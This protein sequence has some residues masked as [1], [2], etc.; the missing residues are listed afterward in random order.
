MAQRTFR[1][2][3]LAG[4]L[5]L[6][7]VA[8]ACGD[9]SE[10]SDGTKTTQKST[11][12]A[13]LDTTS[14][15]KL[16]Y[17]K[18]APKG[19]TFTDY[20][21]M[22]DSGTNTSFD[23][24]VVQTLN[25]SQITTSLFDGL[26]DFDFSDKCNPELKGAVAEDWEGNE[27]ATEF[28]FNIK[29]DQVFS[30]GT[31]V[32]PSSFKAGWERAGSAELASP[33]GYL[34]SYIKGGDVLQAGCADD[35]APEEGADCKEPAPDTLDAIVADDDAMT[36]TVT[37]AS[38]NA[39]FPSIVSHPFFSPVNKK[40][41]AKIGKTTGWGTKGL[42]I[43]NGPFMLDSS[44]TADADTTLVPNPKWT[45]NVY[46][47]TEV[48]LD[49]LVFKASLDVETAYQTFEAGEGDDA[50]VPSG[51]YQ[52]ALAAYKKNTVEDPNVGSY[53][54]DFGED[55]PQVGGPENVKLRQAI[56]LA[57]DRE[58]INT[59]VY[60]G[61]RQISTGIVPPG[62]PGY[63]ADLSKFTKLD[64]T[65]AKKLYK[66]WQDDGGKL[67]KPIRIDFNE[68][69]SHGDVAQIVQA[70]IKDNLGI[71][72][73]LGGVAEDYFKVVAEPGGCQLCRAG[74]YAD[75]PTYGNFMVDL[76]SKASIGANNFGRFEN[77]D[78][79]KAIK[80]AQ[81]E[82]DDTKRGELYNEAEDIL[83]NKQTATVP[84]VYYTGGQVFN[85]RVSN[86]DQP[87]LGIMLWERVAV[88]G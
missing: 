14:C 80:E 72:T 81:A 50:P 11:D 21:F 79:E 39:D 66:E 76:F 68:G 86:Y 16:E 75:Y 42:T 43:G 87:P 45:G 40:D 18:D 85:D 31:P 73:E 58:E 33:Y 5:A 67:T 37:L 51:K 48:H 62:I 17:D 15:G 64:V 27:D 29:D 4:A 54:F 74:W 7:L 53:Y 3:L 28:K 10:S 88:D 60:E 30:D 36:L 49:K 6:A 55:D 23:P 46:G 41:L 9:S 52:D 20:A 71:E 24:G 83:L 69:G 59:K 61:T 34:I 12:N 13:A 63:K 44:T 84:L 35:P 2:G 70:N 26:T 38:P 47:D 22:A 8:S 1:S 57:I 32:L 78:F 25:E 65:E 19:G 56:S 82:T 77:D